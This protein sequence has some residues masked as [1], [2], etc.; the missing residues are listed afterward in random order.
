MWTGQLF[1]RLK[2]CSVQC[3]RGP[4]VTCSVGVCYVFIYF[5][6]LPVLH[7]CDS[8]ACRCIYHEAWSTDIKITAYKF[9][10]GLDPS[11]VFHS[12]IALHLNLPICVQVVL[13]GQ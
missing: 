10:I 9:I 4:R 13:S 7:M 5:P 2:I 12:I 11:K 1:E 6:G 3:K 8:Q